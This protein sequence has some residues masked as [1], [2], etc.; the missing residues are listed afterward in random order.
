MKKRIA[1]VLVALVLSFSC[2]IGTTLAWLTDKTDSVVNTFTYGDI[3][4]EL[5]EHPIKDNGYELDASATVVKNEDG[6]K[7]IPGTILDKDPYVEIAV[8]SEACW[9]FIKIE[10]S[11]GNVTIGEKTYSFDDFLVYAIETGWTLYV[12]GTTTGDIVNTNGTEINTNTNDTYVI[13]QSVDS[14]VGATEATKLP[15]LGSGNYTDTAV[16]PNSLVNWSD[17]ELAVKPSVTKQMLNLLDKDGSGNA[18][19]TK[20]YPKLTFTAYA[21]QKDNATTGID[22]VA[23]AYAIA[24]NN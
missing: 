2:I 11:G 5:W 14:T 4:I 24:F 20:L 23:E 17:N 15:I 21:V 12:D 3:D 18:L 7:M 1:V 13:Y 19:A 9:V 22:T 6:Y 8:G 10:E 16:T